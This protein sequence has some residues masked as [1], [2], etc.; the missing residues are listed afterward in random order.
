M[1]SLDTAARTGSALV[2]LRRGWLHVVA[3]T[4]SALP[5]PDSRTS[6]CGYSCRVIQ[7]GESEMPFVSLGTLLVHDKALLG[8]LSEMDTKFT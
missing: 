3:E 6:R 1:F 5:I 2:R 4:A 7:L 8:V